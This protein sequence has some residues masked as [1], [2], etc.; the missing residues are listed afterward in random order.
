MSP[1]GGQGANASIADALALA[2]VADEG[3]RCGNVSAAGLRSYEDRRRS[4]NARSVGI[5][6]TAERTFRMAGPFATL[7]GPLL[8]FLLKSATFLRVPRRGL[9]FFST[10]FVGEEEVEEVKR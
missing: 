10:A 2:V 9:R 1:A 8:P 3:L 5:S 7:G 6:A 4:A